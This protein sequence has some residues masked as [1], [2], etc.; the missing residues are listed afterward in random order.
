MADTSTLY[1][2]PALTA[3]MGFGDEGQLQQQPGPQAPSPGIGV[4]ANDSGSQDPLR[5]AVDAQPGIGV[6]P[7]EQAPAAAPAQDAGFSWPRTEGGDRK[8]IREMIGIGPSHETTMK[9]QQERQT[10]LTTLKESLTALEQGSATAVGMASGESKDKFVDAYAGKLDAIQPGLGDTFKAVASKPGFMEQMAKYANK[11]PTIR[12]ALEVDPTGKTAFA[13]MKSPEA[14]GTIQKEIDANVMPTILKKGQTFLMGW[15]QIVPKEMVDRFNKDGRLSASE[16]IQANEWIKENKPDL[17][18]TLALN[19]EELGTVHRNSEAFY[20]TLGIVSPKDEGEV[21]KAQ[22]KGE[23]KNPV[24]RT[25][26]KNVNGQV[27][28]QQQEWTGG[29]WENVGDLVPHFKPNEATGGA[30]PQEL[31]HLHGEDYLAKLPTGEGGLIRQIGE[32]KINPGSLS[33]RDGH[34]E[35]VLQQVVQAYPDFDQTNYGARAAVRKAFTSGPDA[36]NATKINTAIGHIGTMKDLGDKLGNKDLRAWNQM[37]NSIGVQLGADEATNFEVV[38]GAVADELMRVFRGVGASEKEAEAW[39]QRF[40]TAGS[41]K[42]INGAIATAADLLGSRIES[43]NDK[44]KRGM[45]TDQGF[46]KL[47]SDKSKATFKAIG[48]RLDRYGIEDKG[49]AAGESNPPATNSKG[50]PL[51]IDASGNKAYVGPNKEIEAVK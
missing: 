6:A 35:K 12:R 19:D 27:M 10:Q 41:P 9:R 5:A 11:S 18:K 42:Q 40:K 46:P 4:A 49:A 15:Q 43:L 39:Q 1:Q 21:L 36:E 25:L 33:T 7:Q 8:T 48:G 13:L 3:G 47:L 14:Q 51:M 26:K 28:E 29:K 38:R 24:T 37:A 44:W 17:A 22:A 30:V 45:G 20:H 34:R 32:G 31:A 23:N 16:L 2:D 50:W